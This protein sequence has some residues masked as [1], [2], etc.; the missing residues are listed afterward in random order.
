MKYARD[1]ILVVSKPQNSYMSH[2]L[3]E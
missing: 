2:L 3:G 1:K